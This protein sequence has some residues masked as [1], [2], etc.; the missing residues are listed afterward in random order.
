M[1]TK[2][3]WSVLA[4]QYGV[5]EHC[6]DGLAGYLSGDYKRPGGF[7]TAVLSNDL[8]GAFGKADETNMLAIRTYVLFL[9]NEAPGGSY[10]SPE[11]VN[12]WLTRGEI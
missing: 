8:F 7:L 5:P 9:Y 11:H 2:A 3:E 1:K 12:D 6:V 10:G 4:R